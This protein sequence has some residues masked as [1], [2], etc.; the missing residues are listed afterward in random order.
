DGKIK[1]VFDDPQRAM[2]CGQSLVLYQGDLVLGGGI[3]RK[4]F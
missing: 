3:M 2:T 1:I 4:Y